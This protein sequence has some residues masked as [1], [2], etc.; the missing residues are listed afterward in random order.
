MTRVVVVPSTLA[1]LPQY[2][3]IDDPIAG[4]RAAVSAAVDWLVEDAPAELVA[5]TPPAQRIGRH[6]LGSRL[7]S[8]ATGDQGVLVVANGSATRTEKAPGHF[9]ERS[10]PFDAALGKALAD[11][12][13][14]ALCDLDLALAD[15]LWVPDAPGFVELGALVAR[16]VADV[17]IDYDDAPYGVQYWVVRWLCES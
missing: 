15:E 1:L 13:R 4:L 3:S 14:S 5:A 11:G 7:V 17:R 16:P 2:T 8:T 9:D 6:L 12:D 10:E